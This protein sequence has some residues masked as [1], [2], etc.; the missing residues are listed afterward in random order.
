MKRSEVYE[1]IDAERDYQ[2]NFRPML[3]A[4]SDS[5]HSV[6]D[7]VL[8]LEHLLSEAKYEIYQMDDAA[9][10]Q[11]IR[12]LTAVGVACMENNDTDPR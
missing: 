5:D 12:K 2:D 8:F 6:A 1:L 4:K 3:G 11:Y 7:W 10:L 9:A